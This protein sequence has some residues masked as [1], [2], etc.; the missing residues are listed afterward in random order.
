MAGVCPYVAVT[1]S[2]SCLGR[3]GEGVV[4]S[5]GATTVVVV[6]ISCG[7]SGA[8]SSSIA[9]MTELVL[10]VLMQVFE[11]EMGQEVLAVGCRK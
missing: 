6:L 1:V 7:R 3:R 8:L 2:S 11:E 9:I 4:G 10:V 5:G